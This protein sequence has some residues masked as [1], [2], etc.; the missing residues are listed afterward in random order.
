MYIEVAELPPK[1][2]VVAAT[3]SQ[4]RWQVA[5][6]ADS[7]LDREMAWMSELE[8]AAVGMTANMSKVLA[9]AKSAY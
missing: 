5:C 4:N 7:I 3:V 8:M 9:T 6:P 2:D 1:S